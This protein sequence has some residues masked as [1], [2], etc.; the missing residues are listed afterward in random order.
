MSGDPVG[1]V[2]DEARALGEALRRARRDAAAEAG[3]AVGDSA[4]AERILRLVAEPGVA[5][6]RTPGAPDAS[7]PEGPAPDG[8]GAATTDPAG[9]DSCPW[10][11][12]RRWAR[13]HGPQVLRDLADAGE[14]LV[15]GLRSAAR[16]LEARTST[17]PHDLHDL[18]DAREQE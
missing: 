12:S 13:A 18:H 2:E 16:T 8:R 17:H 7:E 9:C 4:P 6:H 15:H 14:L 5:G 11:R 10:C 3:E 1:S